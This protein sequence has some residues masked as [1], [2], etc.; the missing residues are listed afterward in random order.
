MYFHL[1]VSDATCRPPDA[2]GTVGVS[3][4]V[5]SGLV[6]S[7]PCSYPTPIFFQGSRSFA[8]CLAPL[9]FPLFIAVALDLIAGAK[10]V[11]LPPRAGS[12]AHL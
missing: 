4:A 11:L 7:P 3:L 9:N 5:S 2:S 1:M 8:A 12:P 6:Y 10:W